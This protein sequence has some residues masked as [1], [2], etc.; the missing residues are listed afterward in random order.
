MGIDIESYRV[1]IGMFVPKGPKCFKSR[2]SFKFTN[3]LENLKFNKSKKTT[4]QEIFIS[5]LVWI[6]LLTMSTMK[7][8]NNQSQITEN[9]QKFGHSCDVFQTLPSSFSV[10]ISWSY[11]SANG[12]LMHYI[13]G[14][15]RNLGYKYFSWNCD[16]GLL[17]KHK[18][19]DVRIFAQKHKPHFMSIS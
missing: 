19:E 10:G 17:S 16:R 18:I 11:S 9:K 6:L 15:R 7:I 4:L 12:N 1:R 14:N 5:S 8:R 13:Y 2:N 3:N